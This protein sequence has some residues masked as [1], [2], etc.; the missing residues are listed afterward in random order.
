M[1]NINFLLFFRL[2]L[3]TLSLSG[4][5]IDEVEHP[6]Y[7]LLHSDGKFE[8]RTYNPMLVADVIVHGT[9]YEAIRAG[10]KVLADYLDDITSTAV[11]PEF[12]TI[13]GL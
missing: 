7:Q 8:L 1:K 6:E 11:I 9:Q 13:M 10:F 5:S 3:M 2:L 4:C 12:S